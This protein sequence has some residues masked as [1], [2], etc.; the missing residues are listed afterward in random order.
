MMLLQI[1]DSYPVPKKL[2]YGDEAY[3]RVSWAL[4]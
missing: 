1:S 4:I 2:Q 3:V